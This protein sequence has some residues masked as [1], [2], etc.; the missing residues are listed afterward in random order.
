VNRAGG[1]GL[2]RSALSIIAGWRL[3]ELRPELEALTYENQ[4]LEELRLSTLAQISK[5]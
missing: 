4:E 1:K 2:K 3:K 5:P